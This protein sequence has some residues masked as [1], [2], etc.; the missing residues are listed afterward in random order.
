MSI[1]T[2]FVPIRGDG[3]GELVLN[4]A[5]ALGQR[6]S[7]HIEVNHCRPR[8][9]DLL[10]AGAYL[11][12]AMRKTITDS[13]Q[14]MADDE[15]KRLRQ[16][17]DAYCKRHDLTVVETLPWPAHEMSVSWRE[18]TGKQQPVKTPVSI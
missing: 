14:T 3:N 7:A 17:F 6:F 2:I 9:D 18:R 1:R 10:P 15:E 16:I 4:H 8:P 12:A 11:N 13:A 5:L